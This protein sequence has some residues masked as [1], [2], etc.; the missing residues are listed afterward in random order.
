HLPDPWWHQGVANEHG[1]AHE[2]VDVFEQ[3]VTEFREWLCQQHTHSL[4]VVGHGNLFKALIGRM[5]ENCEVHIF[6]SQQPE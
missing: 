5:L 4:A 2:P 3:R 1:V 6:E